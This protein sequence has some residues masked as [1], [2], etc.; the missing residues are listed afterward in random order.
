MEV[1]HSY[2]GGYGGGLHPA[3]VLVAHQR[4]ERNFGH[5]M[6]RPDFVSPA[7]RFRIRYGRSGRVRAY[8]SDNGSRHNR[9]LGG[10]NVPDRPGNGCD[11]TGFLPPR[12]AL[13]RGMETD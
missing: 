7:G 6:R 1:P 3:L 12:E 5:V 4:V 13:A 9:G 8:D 2:R 10:G 11:A